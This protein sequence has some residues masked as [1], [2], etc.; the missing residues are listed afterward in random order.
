MTCDEIRPNLDRYVDGELDEPTRRAVETHLPRCPECAKELE[1]LEALTGATAG[2][3]PKLPAPGGFDSAVMNRLPRHPVN[4]FVP[5]WLTWNRVALAAVVLLVCYT[6]YVANLERFTSNGRL[7]LL[8]QQSLAWSA[9]ASMRVMGFRD[10]DSQ[11]P[12]A[13]TPVVM[14]ARRENGGGWRTL[15]RGRTNDVGSV[16]ASFRLPPDLEGPCVLRVQSGGLFSRDEI[17]QRIDV[18]R[19]ARVL[20]SSDKPIYQPGQLIHLRVLAM[21]IGAGKAAAERPVVLEVKEPKGA[22]VFRK[23]SVTS[24]FGIA[25]ADFQL[26]DLVSHGRYQVTA[27]VGDDTTE[28]SVTVKPYVLPKFRVDLDPGRTYYSP[29]DTL[30]AAVKSAYFFGKPVSGARVK[31][32]LSALDFEFAPFATL[33]GKT[34]TNGNFEFETRIPAGFAGHPLQQGNALISLS[35][36]VTDA[37]GHLE[38]VTKTVPV[39]AEPFHIAVVPES[40]KPAWALEN[41]FYLVTSYPD[42]AVARTSGELRTNGR[43]FRFETDESGIGTVRVPVGLGVF[44]VE[45]EATD[46]RGRRSVTQREWA[47]DAMDPG[48]VL[49]RTE[50]SLY[51]VGQT[52]NVE[53][54]ASGQASTVYVDVVR[55]GQTVLTRA[56]SLQDGRGRFALD[57]SEDLTGALAL[58]AYFLPTVNGIIRDTHLVIVRPGNQLQVA[59]EPAQ[60]TFRPGEE[61]RVRVR[62][63]DAAGQG[64]PGAVGLAAVDESV[65]ALR[66]QAPGLERD[67]FEMEKDLLEPRFDA[68]LELPPAFAPTRVLNGPAPQERATVTLAA[69]STNGFDRLRAGGEVDSTGLT[70][71]RFG[72]WA[73]SVPFRARAIK[74][75]QE[76]FFRGLWWSLILAA[77][78]GSSLVVVR[79]NAWGLLLSLPFFAAAFGLVSAFGEAALPG[80]AAIA[81]YTGLCAIGVANRARGAASW[82]VAGVLLLSAAAI[83]F[84]VFAPAREAARKGGST[85]AGA[86]GEPSAAP[87]MKVADTAQSAMPAGMPAGM[88]GGPGTVARP[89]PRVREY[90][91]ETL[92]WSPEVVT[93]DQGEAEVTLPS[94]DSITTWR[95]TGTGSTADGKVGSSS[96]GVRV[97]QDFFLDLDLPLTVTQYDR[98]T[99]PVAVHNYLA[100][101]QTVRVTLKPDAW[102]ELQGPGTR[103]L[104]LAPNG[105]GVV[106]FPITAR[107]FGRHSLEVTASGATLSDA[108]RREIEVKP[109]GE[110]TTSVINDRLDSESSHSLTFPAWTIPGTEQLVLKLHPGAFSQVVDGLEGL[111]AVPYGCMEQSTSVTYPNVLILNY[112]SSSGTAA[113]EVRMKAEQLVNVGY[114]RLLTF[115][116]PGGG[117]DWYGNP[118]ASTVLTAYGL[119]HL[120]DMSRVAPVDDG[121]IDRARALLESRQMDDGSWEPAGMLHEQQLATNPALASTAYVAWSLARSGGASDSVERA[122]AYLQEHV[123]PTADVYTL[124]LTANAFAAAQ[125]ESGATRRYLDMLEQRKTTERNA[126]FWQTTRRTLTYGGGNTGDV[127]TTALAALAYLTANYRTDLASGAIAYLL[128]QRDPRGAWGSTQAT[129]LSLQALVAASGGMAERAS[130]AVEVKVNGRAATTIQLTEKNFDVMQQVDLTQF[131]TPGENRVTLTPRGRVKPAYQ[132]VQHG[133]VPWRGETARATKPGIEMEVTYDRSQLRQNDTLTAT[134]RIRSNQTSRLEMLIADVGLAPGFVPDVASL[135]ALVKSKRIDRYE[136]T[137]RQLILYLRH[138]A[139]GEE[140]RLPVRMRARFPVRAKSAPSAA[141]EYYNPSN[142]VRS[143]PVSVHVRI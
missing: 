105:V 4:P 10:R 6:G 42:G 113:P 56:T 35:A 29:G 89:A 20:L 90:F 130:G 69:L 34:D 134:V 75:H 76:G 67:Y 47:D 88:G 95:L 49:V 143:K 23:E 15:F 36:E 68:H 138:L 11:E 139:H 136:V 121:L 22:V 99:V 14:S 97:F 117:F 124:A 66:E 87:T 63:T 12:L 28:K 107:R 123:G 64:V 98:I 41:V 13:G 106:R 50:A 21:D 111:L 65:F 92:F 45:V 100:T 44:A 37:A 119:T 60:E 27:R 48:S 115:E 55:A 19:K 83:L 52:M 128:R 3:L 142:R 85:A 26:A 93:N 137:P 40:G 118:P 135:D 96:T 59:L 129:I 125:P 114:Q 110:Q 109:D 51:E 9:P 77:L 17:Q 140:L 122:L 25:S 81:T 84:P 39:A 86:A 80:A 73:D 120:V 104:T 132:L 18:K 72:V 24:R 101:S 38:E 53:V 71:P 5:M 16:D 58:H 61:P 112:L 126:S 94:A 131:L 33:S 57:L 62:L 127:E 1:L 7:V 79:R 70:A 31:V 74:Q 30:D 141:Y 91:P 32:R 103:A 82:A 78:F 54:L 116:V 8:G 43:S 2:V 108:Q 133:Y 102:F 46:S